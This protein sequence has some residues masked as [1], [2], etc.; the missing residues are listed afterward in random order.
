[1]SYPTDISPED[2]KIVDQ[3]EKEYSSDIVIVKRARGSGPGVS[4]RKVNVYVDGLLQTMS[5][6]LLEQMIDNGFFVVVTRK[7]GGST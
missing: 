7:P 4:A 5:E 6:D 1:M 3:F 2:Q